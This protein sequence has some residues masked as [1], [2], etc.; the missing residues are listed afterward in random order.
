MARKSELEIFSI[1]GQIED[2]AARMMIE[3]HMATKIEYEAIPMEARFN[4]DGATA[5]YA[6][7]FT[8]RQ[9]VRDFEELVA[10]L[11]V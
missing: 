9:Q 8:S 11:R 7:L 10:D 1:F 3:K 6:V 5:K 4:K 2:C